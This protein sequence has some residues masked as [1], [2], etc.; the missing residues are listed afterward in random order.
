[1]K[2]LLAF[3]ADVL[4]RNAD[5]SSAIHTAS[6]HG[7]YKL[8]R[9]FMPLCE[10]KIV[11]L[12]DKAGDTPVHSCCISDNWVCMEVFFEFG[13]M[14][15]RDVDER[16]AEGRTPLTLAAMNSSF[17]MCRRLLEMGADPNATDLAGR[18]VLLHAASVPGNEAVVNLLLA[19]QRIMID[20]PDDNGLTPIAAVVEAKDIRILR[21]LLT[22]GASPNSV[23]AGTLYTPLHKAVLGKWME[24]V[25]ALLG[26]GVSCFVLRDARGCTP[27]DYA[28][29]KDV[30]ELVQDYIEAE[31]PAYREGHPVTFDFALVLYDGRWVTRVDGDNIGHKELKRRKVSKAIAN[32]R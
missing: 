32:A 25:D 9:E 8:L 7:Q 20:M 16:G 23:E 14:V 27:L 5:G 22:A 13:R 2:E 30:Q 21:S 18:S 3:G 1:M 11:D 10:A 4:M 26:P 28:R 15:S 19:D 6:L 31:E 29:T 24:G 12:K 17:R